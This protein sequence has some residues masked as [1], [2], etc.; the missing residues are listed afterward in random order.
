MK[1]FVVAAP[2]TSDPISSA[3]RAAFGRPDCV[4]DD[5]SALLLRIDQVDR[6]TGGSC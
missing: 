1:G 5:F 2:R 6:K 4:S 3:L